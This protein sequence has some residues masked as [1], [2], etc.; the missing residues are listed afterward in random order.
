[1]LKHRNDP[2]LVNLVGQ[3][4]GLDQSAINEALKGVRQVREDWEKA[5]LGA[6]TPEQAAAMQRMQEAWVSLDQAITSVGRDLVMGVGP[7][8][9]AIAK[10]VAGWTDGNRG[11]ADSIGGILAAITGFTALKPAAWVLRL[12][13][14]EGVVA[15]AGPAGLAIGGA[16]ALAPSEVNSGEKN[17]YANGKLTDYGKSL[18]A[19]DQKLKLAGGAAAGGGSG[20]FGSQAEKEAYSRRSIKTK[21]APPGGFFIWRT[22]SA[23]RV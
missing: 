20:A 13:G 14:L 2:Q 19:A 16:Y 22:A 7:A 5:K 4:G 17:I 8:F 18:I 11:L 12:L 9:T 21:A 15:A 1:M 3:M 23:I 10:A 6:L